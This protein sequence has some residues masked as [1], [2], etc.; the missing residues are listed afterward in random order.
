MDSQK[1]MILEELMGFENSVKNVELHVRAKNQPNYITWD[2]PEYLESYITNLNEAT[3]RLQRENAR[4]KKLHQKVID[5]IKDLFNYNLTTEKDK[6]LDILASIKHLVDLACSNKD[7]K[8]CRRWR[9][10]CDVQLYR[11]LEMQYLRGVEEME[12]SVLDIDVEVVFRN[13][14]ISFKPSLE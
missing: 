7:P 9:T 1:G 11:V 3:N 4:L 10:H 14:T 5:T 13:K 8:Q 2:N 12:T 6:W